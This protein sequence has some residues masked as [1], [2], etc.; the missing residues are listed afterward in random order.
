MHNKEVFYNHFPFCLLYLN[1]KA[2]N[3][4]TCHVTLRCIYTTIV[5]Q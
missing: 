3:V 1:K 2:D 5:A 4:R